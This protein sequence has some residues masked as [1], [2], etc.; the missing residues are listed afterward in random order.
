MLL[1]GNLAH[2][3]DLPPDAA[4]FRDKIKAAEDLDK[5]EGL[6]VPRGTDD[7]LGAPPMMPGLPPRLAQGTKVRDKLSGQTGSVA[8]APG[9]PGMDYGDV[10]FVKWDA[11]GTTRPVLSEFLEPVPTAAPIVPM[12]PSPG[13]GAVQAPPLAPKP[14]LPKAVAKKPELAEGAAAPDSPIPDKKTSTNAALHRRAM[15]ARL[16]RPV[17]RAAAAPVAAPPAGPAKVSASVA[18][19]SDDPVITKAGDARALR[20]SQLVAKLKAGAGKTH[21]DALTII[22]YVPQG[23]DQL[24]AR[25]MG[26]GVMLRSPK[27][28][29][30]VGAMVKAKFTENEIRY[31]LGCKGVPMY[32][33]DRVF[34]QLKAGEP[35]KPMPTEDPGQGMVWAWNQTTQDWYKTDKAG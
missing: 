4:E 29:F 15:N 34:G 30:D 32:A 5:A 20:Y 18:P 13:A 17:T 35:S 10:V 3:P 14:G 25:L 31:I 11:D 12:M 8:E 22:G 23:W 33:L 26:D 19:T 27:S 9:G 7:G 1:L 6:D 21:G 16:S 28:A 2:L 24:V